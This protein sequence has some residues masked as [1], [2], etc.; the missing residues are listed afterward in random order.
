MRLLLDNRAW[1]RLKLAR[2]DRGRALEIADAMQGGAVVACCPFLL[3]GSSARNARDHDRMMDLLLALP[4]FG[5]DDEVEKRA[6]QAQRELAQVGRH[7][8]HRDARGLR[9]GGAI[10]Q[11]DRGAARLR[12]RPPRQLRR[13]LAVERRHARPGRR[14]WW[15]K[16]IAL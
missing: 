16:T 3:A 10:D 2:L 6:A 14:C 9:H 13:Q 5:V 11:Q 15:A 4:R 12:G 8:R 1:A 7:R